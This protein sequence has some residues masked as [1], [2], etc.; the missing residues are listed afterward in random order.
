M[1]KRST[2]I[3]I[4]EVKDFEYRVVSSSGNTY[5]VKITGHVDLPGHPAEYGLLW[6]CNCPARK[7]CCHLEGVIEYR[8]NLGL[9]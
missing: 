7:T 5:T 4:E 2:V 9:N 1:A 8:S 3:N 6:E